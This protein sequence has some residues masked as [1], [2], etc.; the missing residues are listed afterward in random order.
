MWRFV[1]LFT[2]I[3][4]EEGG[5]SAQRKAHFVGYLSLYWACLYA[6]RNGVHA[7]M[8]EESVTMARA[9]G[10]AAKGY[11]VQVSIF[12]SSQMLFYSLNCLYHIY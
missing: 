10:S 11:V 2:A 1:L 6:H 4:E 8:P 12:S 9:Q 5:Y 7:N 3:M